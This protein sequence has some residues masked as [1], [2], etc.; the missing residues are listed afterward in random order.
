MYLLSTIL[1]LS[2]MITFFFPDLVERFANYNEKTQLLH[3]WNIFSFTILLIILFNIQI[4]IFV[5]TISSIFYHLL[6]LTQNKINRNFVIVS[7]IVNSLI[8]IEQLNSLSKFK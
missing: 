5:C 2:C 7:V 8:I 6:L 3:I 4:A 1:S